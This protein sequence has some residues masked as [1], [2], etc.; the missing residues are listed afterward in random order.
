MAYIVSIHSFRGGTGKS[1]ITANL[2]AQVALT[3]KKVAIIDT[4]IQSPGIHVPFG[5]DADTMGHTLNEFLNGEC[6]IQ[7]AALSI[8]DFP[9]DD[10]GRLKL[11]G[12]DLWLVPS[13][14]NGGDISQILREGY[15]INRLNEGIQTLLR[16]MEL[17]YLFI[18]THPGLHEETLLSLAISDILL[19]VLRPDQQDFQGTTVTVD[20]ALGLDVPYPF[21]VLNMV[22]TSKYDSAQISKEVEETYGVPVAGV[23]PLAEALVDLGSTDIF[24]LCEPGHAWSKELAK[25]TQAVLSAE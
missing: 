24:T 14:I 7:E 23:L 11:K 22:L 20:I 4:D 15:D 12:Q 19:I 6:T 5:L 2:A 9:G 1:N 8:G 17:D 25:I 3:G 10:P 13:S 21:L 18:D 16:G